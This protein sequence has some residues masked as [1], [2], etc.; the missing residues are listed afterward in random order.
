MQNLLEIHSDSKSL[1]NFQ[2]LFYFSNIFFDYLI[3]IYIY[4]NNAHII[5]IQSI[6]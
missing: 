2:K 1:S 3:Y 6:L 4:L 5:V